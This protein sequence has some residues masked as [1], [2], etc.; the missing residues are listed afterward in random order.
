MLLNYTVPTFG[1][2]ATTVPLMSTKSPPA[3]GIAVFAYVNEFVLSIRTAGTLA[4][5]CLTRCCMQSECTLTSVI[6]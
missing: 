1:L 6:T 2:S 3:D 4:A 5:I